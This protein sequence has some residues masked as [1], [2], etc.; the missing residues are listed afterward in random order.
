MIPLNNT[1]I[2]IST[3]LIE[4]V[5]GKCNLVCSYCYH[6]NI[7]GGE[8]L[9]MPQKILERIIM[10]V[11][12]V[13]E[14]RIKFLW[15]GGE[16]MLAGINFY[17]RVV[18]LQK[19][20]RRS[21]EQTI[22]NHIQ[23]NATLINEKWA[24]FFKENSF[25]VSTSIDGPEWLHDRFRRTKLN[26]GSFQEVIRGIRILRE[27]GM[28][29]GVVTTINYFNVKYPREIYET[30]IDLG[31]KGFDL[32]IAS[33]IPGAETIAPSEEETVNFLKEVFDI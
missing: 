24:R 23:T 2:P 31:L 6:S 20:Y 8:L 33:D 3:L 22:N 17:R 5:G 9:A 30:L 11:L 4:P 14:E 32:N 19:N 7:R 15:H 18:E 29:V 28:N 13:N 16:P 26:Q 12:K 21:E 25:K 10:E 1:E 27:W